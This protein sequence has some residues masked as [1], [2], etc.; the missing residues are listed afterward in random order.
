MLLEIPNDGSLIKAASALNIWAHAY[1]ESLGT[2]EKSE[3]GQRLNQL[4]DSVC[5]GLWR[6]CDY[7]GTPSKQSVLKDY[8]KFRDSVN[9]L[10]T[11]LQ[12]ATQNNHGD[13]EALVKASTLCEEM[14]ELFPEAIQFLSTPD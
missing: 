10:R 4:A 11:E 3:F 9:E 5:G 2:D 12:K 7:P 13:E 1:V 8:L 14:S 6:I